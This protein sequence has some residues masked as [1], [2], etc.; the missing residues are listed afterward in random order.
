MRTPSRFFREGVF[1]F[2]TSPISEPA[3]SQK[4]TGAGIAAPGI[5]QSMSGNT[6]NLYSSA[7]FIKRSQVSGAS[8]A[9]LG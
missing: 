8:L 6:A 3:L 7:T 2:A 1:S 4:N 9:N 5:S